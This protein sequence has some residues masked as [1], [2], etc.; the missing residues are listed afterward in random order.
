MLLSYILN[1]CLHKL[2]QKKKI[3]VHIPA[4]PF[5]IYQEKKRKKTNNYSP[6]R[7]RSYFLTGVNIPL[8]LSTNEL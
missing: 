8:Y 1:L 7:F 2:L 3:E 6:P 4:P 5:I